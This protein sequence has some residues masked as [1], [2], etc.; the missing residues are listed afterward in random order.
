MGTNGNGGSSWI[1]KEKRLAIYR[2]DEFRCVYC[3][4]LLDD[5]HI[6]G[7]WERTLDHLIPRSLGGGNGAHNLVT[8]CIHCNS[9][10]QETGVSQFLRILN[11]MGRTEEIVAAAIDAAIKRHAALYPWDVAHDV[12]DPE[13]GAADFDDEVPF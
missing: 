9:S 6:E 13:E 7:S 5:D 8:A 10:R 11:V 1:R 12:L 4:R 3:G 2:S